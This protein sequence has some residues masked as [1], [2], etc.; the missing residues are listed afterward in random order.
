[1][2]T[3]I[4]ITTSLDEVKRFARELVEES[5]EDLLRSGRIWRR[6]YLFAPAPDAPG[7]AMIV[8]DLDA[9]AEGLLTL[10]SATDP[11]FA[12]VLPQLE[13]AAIAARIPKKEAA[14]RTLNVVLRTLHLDERTIVARYMRHM[15]L[16]FGAYAYVH[17]A[18]TWVARAAFEG[19]S[20]AAGVRE[21]FAKDLSRDPRAR[22]AIV[23]GLETHR[24]QE[25]TTVE[26]RRTERGTGKV[27]LFLE[28]ETLSSDTGKVG[29]ELF[30]ILKPI[31]LN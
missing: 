19:E 10:L 25:M 20:E 12:S 17:V 1:V 28:P 18:D 31:P 21:R 26:Y 16:K 8:L 29:G 11:R 30:D 15:I 9:D 27:E 23:V 5:K 2:S 14:T 24:Y 22:E 13:A 6:C 3:E 7:S 4:T